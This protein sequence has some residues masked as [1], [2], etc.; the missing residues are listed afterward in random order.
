MFKNNKA[1][2]E[3][4]FN[5]CFKKRNIRENRLIRDYTGEIMTIGE[6]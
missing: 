4:F 2:K 3:K 1:K 6:V 5:N